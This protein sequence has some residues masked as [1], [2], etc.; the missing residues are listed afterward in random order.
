MII[1]K[2]QI[3]KALIRL[4]VCAGWS[5]PLLFANPRRQVF[6][7]QGPFVLYRIMA[8]R[9]PYINEQP[10]NLKWISRVATVREK[11]LEDENFSRSGIMGNFIYFQSGK[12]RKKNGKKVME[13]SGNFKN[14]QNKL[15]VNRLLEILFTINCK[16]Y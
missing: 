8:A 16:Q 12:F 11:I 7:H 10:L 15:L 2:M 14:I 1:S 6:S 4:R 5:V 3:K 13:K 9:P